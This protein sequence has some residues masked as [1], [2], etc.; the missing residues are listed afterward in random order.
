MELERASPRGGPG[1]AE[2][3]AEVNLDSTL[4][5]TVLV[6]E[7]VAHEVNR[8]RDSDV[9]VGHLLRRCTA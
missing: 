3:A 5:R 6:L 1:D 9:V 2:E 7:R 4:R 8:L